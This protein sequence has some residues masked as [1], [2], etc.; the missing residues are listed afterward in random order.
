MESV[1]KFDRVVLIKELNDKIKKFGEVFEIANV[2]EDSFVLRETKSRAAVGVISFADFEEHFVH[3]ENFK[4]WTQWTLL[5]TDYDEGLT[6]FYRV[7]DRHR[8]QVKSINGC[9]GESSCNIKFGDEFNLY[10]GL[11]LAFL[12]CIKKVYL[13]KINDYHKQINIY[14]NELKNIEDK[15]EQICSKI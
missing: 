7:K 5:T 10:T 12:R 3:A 15:I 11:N 13:T 2:L 4:G 14:I 6:L 8:V 1:L 9:I